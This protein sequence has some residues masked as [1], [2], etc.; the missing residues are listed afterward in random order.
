[1]NNLV[2]STGGGGSSH[3]TP[4]RIRA[5]QSTFVETDYAREEI[6]MRST[7]SADF[8][9]AVKNKHVDFDGVVG[10]EEA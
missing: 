2:N 1:M 5:A 10:K 4:I 9:E 7:R 6:S 3:R 8:E